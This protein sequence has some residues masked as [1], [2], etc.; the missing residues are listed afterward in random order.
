MLALIDDD[1]LGRLVLKE[2]QVLWK[3]LE[4]WENIYRCFDEGSTLHS[5]QLSKALNA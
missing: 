2:F 3:K 1:D 4:K 5:V